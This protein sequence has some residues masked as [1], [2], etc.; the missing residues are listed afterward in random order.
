MPAT[1][2]RFY[3][4]TSID[5]KRLHER[6]VVFWVNFN[7]WC[8]IHLTALFRKKQ[9]GGRR[10]YSSRKRV[11]LK[12]RC[13]IYIKGVNVFLLLINFQTLLAGLSRHLHYFESILWLMGKTPQNRAF[14]RYRLIM[15]IY[16]KIT[17]YYHYS[18]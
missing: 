16:I 11:F 10:V 2:Y 12:K 15:T 7:V 3:K 9:R 17:N 13:E 5:V 6:N 1:V 18:N 4:C 8:G 14:R